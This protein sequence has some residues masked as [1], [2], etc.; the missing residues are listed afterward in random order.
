MWELIVLMKRGFVGV[1][2][3]GFAVTLEIV[4]QSLVQKEPLLLCFRKMGCSVV[5]RQ[6]LNR[7]ILKNSTQTIRRQKML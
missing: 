1:V 2:E 5:L 6:L 7:S 3:G 4:I